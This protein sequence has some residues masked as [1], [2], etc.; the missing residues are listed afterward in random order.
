MVSTET[1]VGGAEIEREED[2][3]EMRTCLLENNLAV[4]STLSF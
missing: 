1:M 3:G 4:L 2:E